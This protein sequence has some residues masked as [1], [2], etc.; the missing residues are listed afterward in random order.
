MFQ[1]KLNNFFQKVFF[2]K[3]KDLK[4]VKFVNFE[5]YLNFLFVE[6]EKT[7][8]KK[9]F[10]FLHFKLSNSNSYL[11]ILYG[12]KLI[13]WNSVKSFKTKSK[14]FKF[15]FFNSIKL[16]CN[17]AIFFFGKLIKNLKKKKLNLFLLFSGLNKYR[18]YISKFFVFNSF[19]MVLNI[20]SMS[21]S[22]HNGVRCKKSRRLAKKK[23]RKFFMFAEF[24][25]RK[26]N[27]FFFFFK[28]FDFFFLQDFFL[29]FNIFFFFNISKFN[30]LSF[31]KNEIKV[32]R[33]PISFGKQR[34]SFF[35]KVFFAKFNIFFFGS[36]FLRFYF[37][38]WLRNFMLDK[39][40]I[41][42]KILSK[43]KSYK[44]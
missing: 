29:K 2:F 6:V 43:R 31:R 16:L 7:F 5:K 37:L 44:F 33:A 32:L 23:R 42:L 14:K 34:N 40:S 24:K 36:N 26:K 1:L 3:K 11:T 15:Y 9:K 19:F 35:K 38:E 30:F 8:F 27:I 10:F 25:K 4:L 13:F 18:R 12:N 41:N 22:S 39:F 28:S 21:F 20:Y 17:S